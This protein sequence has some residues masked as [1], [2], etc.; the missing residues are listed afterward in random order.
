MKLGVQQS[1]QWE[2]KNDSIDVSSPFRVEMVNDQSRIKMISYSDSSAVFSISDGRFLPIGG[3]S[4][5]EIK[6]EKLNGK[7]YG[8]NYEIYTAVKDN[9]PASVLEVRY[10]KD[11]IPVDQLFFNG[12]VFIKIR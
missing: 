3:K 6:N 7:I 10:L 2:L 8:I 1:V 5:Y 12:K 11:H 4:H 9:I